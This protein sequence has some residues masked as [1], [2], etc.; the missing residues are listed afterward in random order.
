MG[1]DI[2]IRTLVGAH[3]QP[4]AFSIHGVHWLAQPSYLNSGNRNVQAMGISEH[5]EMRFKMP[6]AAAPREGTN[7]VK[8]GA[9]YFY[10]A[11]TGAVGLSNGLW[12]IMR[13]Y[14]QE[15]ASLRPLINNPVSDLPKPISFEAEFKKAKKAGA[16]FKE[17]RVHATTL[18]QAKA[19]ALV[20][21]S[22]VPGFSD[23]N[24]VIFVEEGDLPKLQQA[25]RAFRTVDPARC[26][27]R[28]DQSD[29]DQ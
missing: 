24:A 3:L 5:Y 11:S 22:R 20:Y 12:G 1:D 2:Q 7:V 18:A 10:S 13:S 19:K 23:P 9:D 21:N 29:I 15:L 14:Q 6:S 4:H 25:G 8:D 16:H 26:G 27:W 28:L 17:F